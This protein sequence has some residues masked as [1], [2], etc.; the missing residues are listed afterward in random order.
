MTLPE[1]HR[2]SASPGI[3]PSSA[4]NVQLPPSS[5]IRSAKISELRSLHYC[6][7]VTL[8][9]ERTASSGLLYVNHT[10]RHSTHLD[11][12]RHVLSQH[13]L[14]R[15]E[16]ADALLNTTQRSPI[17]HTPPVS[18]TD[19]KPCCRHPSPA[20]PQAVLH[21]RT[22][23]DLIP[24]CSPTS[25]SLVCAQIDPLRPGPDRPALGLG[26]SA[27]DGRRLLMFTTRQ[28]VPLCSPYDW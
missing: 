10:G 13:P 18:F 26:A 7:G 14:S 22:C 20:D 6:T 19:C 3:R 4:F 27:R 5:P 1:P 28:H 16:D 24:A 9:P 17:L 25:S 23:G 12:P 11:A 2:R 8:S 21:M 15:N